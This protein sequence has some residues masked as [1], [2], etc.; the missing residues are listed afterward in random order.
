[1]TQNPRIVNAF[2]LERMKMLITTYAAATDEM[3]ELLKSAAIT[4]AAAFRIEEHLARARA[5]VDALNASV[6]TH[7]GPIIQGYWNEGV[8]FAKKAL[9]DQGVRIGPGL[10]FGGVQA[11]TDQMSMDLL[12]ANGT[13]DNSARRIL[14]KTQQTKTAEAAINRN[15]AQGIVQ[16]K[17]RREMVRD[18]QRTIFKDIEEGARV[19]A[20]G[21]NFD[22][23]YY[24]E[25]VAHTR[26]REAVTESIV[27]TCVDAMVELFQVSVHEGACVVCQGLQGKVYALG[28]ADER[29]PTLDKRPPFHPN[30]EHILLPFVVERYDDEEL[31]GYAKMSRDPGF[32]TSRADWEAARKGGALRKEPIDF[33][34]Q[35]RE[36]EKQRKAQ[37]R[38]KRTA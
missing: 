27:E 35:K 17:T 31:A 9:T 37:G 13:L 25:M 8:S 30:C 21:R 10:N 16:G 18:M 38:A 4:P 3:I 33:E 11:V 12:E 34:A 6:A 15:V 22:P 7:T 2:S 26:H 5:V 19:R 20:G 29:F 1:M 14:R 23:S 28:G 24:A 36:R 32:I